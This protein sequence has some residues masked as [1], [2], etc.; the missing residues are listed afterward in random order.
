M[1]ACVIRIVSW[2]A[3]AVLVVAYAWITLRADAD[4][5]VFALLADVSLGVLPDG[6]E[7]VDI[8]AAGDLRSGGRG[9]FAA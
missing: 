3:L 6:A 1:T 2:V 7:C 8:R 9:W 4:D 5:S